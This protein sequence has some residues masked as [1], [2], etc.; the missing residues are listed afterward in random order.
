[1]ADVIGTQEVSIWNK[2]ETK[3]VSV[4]TD[5]STER[6]AV[7]SKEE[8]VTN[9]QLKSSVGTSGTSVSTTDVTLYSFSGAGVIDYI[10]ISE[11]VSSLYEV[12][13]VI[14]GTERFRI[15]MDNLGNVLGLTDGAAPLWASIANKHFNYRPAQ[16][17]FSS[18]FSVIARATSGTRT[19]YH[20]VLFREQV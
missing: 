16:I 20:I 15:T 2:D 18:N 7:V 12:A 13:I 14:D 8:P 9:Y 11:N 17:G 4:I 5:G 6:L 3:A 10:G 19:L 1:M